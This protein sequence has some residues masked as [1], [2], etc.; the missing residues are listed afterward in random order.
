MPS[1]DG[2]MYVWL[3]HRETFFLL[4]YLCFSCVSTKLGNIFHIYLRV[5]AL[6]MGN[7]VKGHR[8]AHTYEKAIID[9]ATFYTPLPTFLWEK[10]FEQVQ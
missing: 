1:I 9:N 7:R 10:E 5:F 8:N 4:L 2:L 6:R 3:I